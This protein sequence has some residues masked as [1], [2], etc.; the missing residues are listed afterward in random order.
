M[1]SPAHDDS[2]RKEIPLVEGFVTEHSLRGI[3][4]Q[5]RAEWIGTTCPVQFVIRA[6]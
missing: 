5:V 4:F 3:Q 2:V 6:S 1:L